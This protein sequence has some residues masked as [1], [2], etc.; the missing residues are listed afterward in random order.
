MGSGEL[1]APL[2]V[3]TGDAE[4]RDIIKDWNTIAQGFRFTPYP[5]GP[6]K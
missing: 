2:E 3:S 4:S 1:A 6:R 5:P